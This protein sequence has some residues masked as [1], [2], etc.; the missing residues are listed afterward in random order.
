MGCPGAVPHYL[1]ALFGQK[2]NFVVYFSGEKPITVISKHGT[3]IF[4]SHYNHFLGNLK[5]KLARKARVN[6]ERVYRIVLIPPG[7]PI[8]LPKSN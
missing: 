6:T 5:E 7:H 1:R 8:I 3:T 2:E 4:F